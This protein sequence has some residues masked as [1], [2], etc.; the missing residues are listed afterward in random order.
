MSDTAKAIRAS[1]TQM[2][3]GRV[4]VTLLTIVLFGLSEELAARQTAETLK[5]ERVTLSDEGRTTNQVEMLIPEK[6]I[7]SGA[8]EPSGATRRRSSSYLIVYFSLP[9]FGPYNARKE[10]SVEAVRASDAWKNYLRAALVVPTGTKTEG[11]G[12][13]LAVLRKVPKDRWFSLD[14]TGSVAIAE[15]M[16]LLDRDFTFTGKDG[17]MVYVEPRGPI[18]LAKRTSTAMNLDIE[19]QIPTSRISSIGHFDEKL[20]AVLA[21]EFEPRKPQV[22][23]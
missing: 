9:S 19:Y 14:S 11:L 21:G 16:R 7:A 3:I 17:A 10:Q 20:L 2:F 4:I 12:E 15:P 1:I 5:T 13:R 22:P 23:N 6:Y 18:T 8:I